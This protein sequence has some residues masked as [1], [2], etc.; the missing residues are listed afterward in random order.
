MKKAEVCISNMHYFFH[1]FALSLAIV[2]TLAAPSLNE[3]EEADWKY[4]IGWDGTTLPANEIGT[5]VGHNGTSLVV[6]RTQI[7]FV[8]IPDYHF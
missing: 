8:H 5:K 4:S 7:S 1:L 6:R 2:A 3:R